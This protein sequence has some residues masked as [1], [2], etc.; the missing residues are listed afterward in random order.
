MHLL[1]INLGELLIPLWRG[2]LKC[3][4]ND[5]KETWD[6]VK[7]V[8]ETW[9]KHGKLVANA[10]KYFPSSFHRPPR[11]PVEKISS[12]YKAT[13]YYSYIFGL[14][15]G[16]FRTI[17]PRKYWK[18]FCKLVQGA[19]ILIQHS[20]TGKQVWEAHSFLIRFVEEYENLYYQRR[21]ERLHFCRPSLH[22]LLH[23][24]PEITRVH[25]E[26]STFLCWDT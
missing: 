16:F 23:T 17:L 21:P 8:G 24:A 3:D 15:P 20:I 2:Q 10:T 25:Q 1:C 18:N 26:Q 11:N 12:G 7:L 5:N 13:E 6:W 9:V 22:T 14:G 4:S 19:Q